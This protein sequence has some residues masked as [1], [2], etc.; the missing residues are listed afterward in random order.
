[1]RRFY[2]V[3]IISVFVLVTTLPT[4]TEE[5]G[6]EFISEGIKYND[7]LLKNCDVRISYTVETTKYPEGGNALR[8]W[9]S[10]EP[11]EYLPPLLKEVERQ[12]GEYDI[13]LKGKKHRIEEKRYEYSSQDGQDTPILFHHHL[14]AYD[15]ENTRRIYYPIENKTRLQGTIW[16][17]QFPPIWNVPLLF[18]DFL[19][20]NTSLS[21][22][23]EIKLTGNA[24]INGHDCYLLESSKM[25][26]EERK[27]KIWVA[28]DMGFR[29]LRFESHTNK[30]VIINEANY[31]NCNGIWA[32]K[33][34]IYQSFFKKSETEKL[35]IY[36][37]ELTVNKL[38]FI[39]SP[40]EIPDSVFALEFPKELKKIWDADMEILIDNPLSEEGGE[41]TTAE[42]L[43]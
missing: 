20:E 11:E 23:P 17:G 7:S 13:V 31:E 26:V 39:C 25:G 1:M 24:Q 34:Q 28:P 32:I 8:D 27:V 12:R 35:R 9:F 22:Y 14:W 36:E 6:L 41:D 42:E 37:R 30:F 16:S 40:E 33:H 5:V 2:L 21:D 15:D 3:V 4:Y 18:A 43:N 29:P 38:E 19:G 10:K